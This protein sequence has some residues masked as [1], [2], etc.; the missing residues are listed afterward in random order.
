MLGK[1]AMEFL[2]HGA[3]VVSSSECGRS[4]ELRS[5]SPARTAVPLGAWAVSSLPPACNAA[6]PGSDS[7]RL[8]T[9][10]EMRHRGAGS[11]V[12]QGA[13]RSDVRCHFPND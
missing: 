5:H 4:V 10:V 13:G 7:E 2:G 11:L 9:P 6:S 12:R 3:C 1:L 8:E